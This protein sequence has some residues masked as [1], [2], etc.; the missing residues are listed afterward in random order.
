MLF[1]PKSRFNSKQN[2]Y[3]EVLIPNKTNNSVKDR[4][5]ATN[6]NTYQERSVPG[7]LT[8]ANDFSNLIA[9]SLHITAIYDSD[10]RP[11]LVADRI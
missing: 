11:V 5:I 9:C 2:N 1:I 8:L 4:Q 6:A 10:S 7:R 3:S